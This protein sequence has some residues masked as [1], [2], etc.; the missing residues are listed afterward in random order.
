MSK[1]VEII[2]LPLNNSNNTLKGKIL[3]KDK[4]NIYVA[5]GRLGKYDYTIKDANRK[6]KWVSTPVDSIV[7]SYELNTLKDDVIIKLPCKNINTAFKIV[8]RK[9]DISIGDNIILKRIPN[10]YKSFNVNYNKV[11]SIP[12]IDKGIEC[13][14][15]NI[16]MWEPGSTVEYRGKKIDI[17]P[18][19]FTLTNVIDKGISKKIST[20]PVYPLYQE[21]YI[22]QSILNNKWTFNVHFRD[23]GTL[24]DIKKS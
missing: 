6:I 15:V 24:F 23:L 13:T 11:A 21:K 2:T 20:E 16:N 4:D 9:N 22:K 3:K 8:P 19:S 1:L 10:K 12:N 14:V 18:G 7:P 17:I 5:L